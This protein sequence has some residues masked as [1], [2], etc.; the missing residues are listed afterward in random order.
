MAEAWTHLAQRVARRQPLLL[1]A[2]VILLLAAAATVV[3]WEGVFAPPASPPAAIVNRP[4]PPFAAKVPPA[5]AAPAPPSF[6]VVRVDRSGHAVMAGRAPPG[7]EVTVASDGKAI[8][9]VE[10]DPEGQWV[11]V[12]SQPLPPGTGALTLSARLPNGKSLAGPDRVV[13]VLPNH[14]GEVPPVAL[15]SGP[16]GAS[17]LIEAPPGASGSSTIGLDLLQ[18]GQHQTLRLSGRAPPNADVRIYVDNRP[19]G[20]AHADAAGHWSLSVAGEIPSGP[21]QIRLDQ[22]SPAGTVLARVAVPFDRPR[23]PLVPEAAA[24]R[25]VVVRPGECLWVIAEHA[26]GNGVRYTLVFQ[27]NHAQIRDPNLIY[28]GQVFT[29]PPSPSA[30]GG[31]G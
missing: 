14:P 16:G 21:H 5:P 13:V 3:R 7:S 6:D 22:I 18:Y 23:P 15:L 28:P 29:L 24:G 1:A 11:L 19:V 9:K 2:A 31:R 8:G 17:R 12:P 20:D 10:S 30:A 27:A 25:V 26:Y 4:T